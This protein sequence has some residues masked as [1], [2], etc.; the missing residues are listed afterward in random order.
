MLVDSSHRNACETLQP[1]QAL[2][3]TTLPSPLVSCALLRERPHATAPGRNEPSSF[4]SAARY[5]DMVRVRTT[6]ADVRSRGITF[7]YVI[8]RVDTGERLVTAR[9]TLISIDATGKPMALPRPVRDLF[10]R[11]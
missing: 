1:S 8:T 6:L 10:D 7:D 3:T 9:T 5:D 4:H 11:Q 2:P